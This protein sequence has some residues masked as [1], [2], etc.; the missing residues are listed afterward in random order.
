MR[1]ASMLCVL[2][3]LWLA[4]LAPVA[5]AQDD[6]S[7]AATEEVNARLDALMKKLQEQE[8]RIEEQEQRIAEL[9]KQRTNEAFEDVRREELEK[10]MRDILADAQL[11]PAMPEWLK[12]LTF[13]GD[14]R[15]RF[16]HVSE[17]RA[18]TE[19]GAHRKDDNRLR[20]R[21]RF[22]FVK[23]WW[24]EQMEVGFRLSTSSPQDDNMTG[25]QRGN[26]RS[27][28]ADMTGIFSKKNI[29]VDLAYAK[30]KPKWAQGLVVTAGKMVAPIRT[31]TDLTWEPTITPEGI[32]AVYDLDLGDFRPYAEAGWWSLQVNA[33]RNT[34]D[35]SI[36]DTDRDVMLWTY[37]G[38]FSWDV[39][40]NF[41]W[42]LGAT[43]WDFV[44]YNTVLQNYNGPDGLWDRPDM[45][46]LE[47]TT[48]TK[49]KL[50]E[51]P[52]SAFFS[53]THNCR[54]T[55]DSQFHER[56]NQNDGFGAGFQVGENRKKGDWSAGY[57]FVYIE[58]HSQ[59]PLVSNAGFNGP[60]SEGHLIHARYNIDDFLTLGTKLYLTEPIVS[61]TD[62]ETRGTRTLLQVEMIW[63][64]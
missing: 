62:Q 4:M 17:S 45:G 6:D 2:G 52:M 33:N 23:T 10:M 15:L 12:N 53:W 1:S 57:T 56:T 42:Q 55:Y 47:L 49:W 25:V 18:F 44:H 32:H 46:M 26:P 64:F 28:N 8:Q 30:Y 24:E 20:Y 29:Y 11:Q 16:Q 9:Q 60:N 54:D 51:L 14:L 19:G 59:A 37:G 58:A 39:A 36:E 31:A 41:N 34:N 40:E 38:G 43:Y 13:S 22:G 3:L 7:G 48:R 21:L 35:D 50:F 27:W 5:I 61:M 63:K